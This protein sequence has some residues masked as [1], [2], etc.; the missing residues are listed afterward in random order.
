[1]VK[2]NFKLAAHYLNRAIAADPQLDAALYNLGLICLKDNLLEE[3]REY[4]RTAYEL[5]PNPRYR[6]ALRVR[7]GANLPHLPIF[8]TQPSRPRWI[9][10]YSQLAN[11]LRR[12]LS[13]QALG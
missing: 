13:P 8:A 6:N 12:F 1:L 4:F 5:N 10:E 7:R 3:A 9:G 11:L 2:N